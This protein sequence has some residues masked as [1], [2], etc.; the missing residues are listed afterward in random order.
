MKEGFSVLY[1]LSKE[2]KCSSTFIVVDAVLLFLGQV[3][4]FFEELHTE[5]GLHYI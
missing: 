2:N 1:I 4:Y 3:S 5:Q